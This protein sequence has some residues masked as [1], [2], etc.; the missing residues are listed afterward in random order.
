[1]RAPVTQL[2]EVLDKCFRTGRMPIILDSSEGGKVLTFYSYQHKN[3]V[4]ET[5]PKKWDQ[6]DRAYFPLDVLFE[7]G[8]QIREDTDVIKR[9]LVKKIWRHLRTSLFA[10]T[11]LIHTCFL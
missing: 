2:E 4:G 9:Y 7:G 1:V 11:V 10:G 5:Q 3:R 8:K 6:D